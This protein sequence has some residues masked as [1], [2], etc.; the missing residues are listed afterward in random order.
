MNT[1]QEVIKIIEE[2]PESTTLDEIMEELYFR[3]KVD[4]GLQDLEKG[5][6]ISHEETKTR[7]SYMIA[8]SSR[9]I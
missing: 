6:L 7:L 3:K 1:K 8:A 5:N 4:Q 9:C 2:L